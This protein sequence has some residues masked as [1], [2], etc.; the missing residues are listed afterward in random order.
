MS[1]S[2]PASPDALASTGWLPLL[3]ESLTRAGAFHWQLSGQS[4]EPTLPDGCQIE[5]VPAS[6]RLS[7]GSLV[8]FAAGSSLVAHRLVYRSGRYLVA[9]GDARREP[10]RWLAPQQIVG[11]VVAARCDG[12]PVWPGRGEGV[13]RWRWIGRAWAL[14]A[15]RRLRRLA[16]H[17]ERSSSS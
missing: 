4:M 1:D 2:P 16:V 11:R 9:Q 6:G 7:L 13:V 5:I 17:P 15:L 8:V 12:R 10:D 3:Q 14:A